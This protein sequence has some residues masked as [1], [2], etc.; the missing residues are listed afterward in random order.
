[1]QPINTVGEASFDEVVEG[2]SPEVRAIAESLRRLIADV[3]PGVT[4][5]VW[6]AQKIAGYGVGP[7]KMSEHFC[8]I[9][10]QRGHANL[11]FVYGAELDDPDGLLEGAGKL[12]RHVKVRTV[13]DVGRAGLRRLLQRASEYLPKL[14]ATPARGHA[15]QAARTS[16][17]SASGGA[18][19]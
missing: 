18:R 15:R 7:K 4:E 8:Y 10:V 9:G 1:M 19:R 16:G 3:M 14:G 6:G 13:D 17:R 12:L 2:A 11:G 5:V